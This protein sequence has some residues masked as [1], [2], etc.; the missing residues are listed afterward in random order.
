MIEDVATIL[1]DSQI[2]YVIIAIASYYYPNPDVATSNGLEG[3]AASG[4]NVTI[5]AAAL[6]ELLAAL[7][8]Q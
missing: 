8:V 2:V 5:S 1:T 7:K 6:Q 3:L 4:Q